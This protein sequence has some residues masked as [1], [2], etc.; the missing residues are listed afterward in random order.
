MLPSYII[1]GSYIVVFNGGVETKQKFCG[2][3]RLALFDV[4]PFDFV[5]H[6]T[7]PGLVGRYMTTK[8]NPPIA[9]LVDNSF[10]TFEGAHLSRRDVLVIIRAF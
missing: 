9:E 5:V 10:T 3:A 7:E 2:T 1:K 8:W 4:C 6:P